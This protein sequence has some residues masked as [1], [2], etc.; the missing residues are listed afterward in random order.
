MERHRQPSVHTLALLEALLERPRA[1]QYG[2]DL[3]RLTAL[4]SG[5]LYP[6]LMRLSDRGALESK[7]QP[8]PQEGRPPRH[9]YR[10]TAAGVLFARESL[11]AQPGGRRLESEGRYA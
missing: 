9:L 10:L 11:A 5:T 7:W 6:I 2:Y 1:W 3:S 8:S 4:K